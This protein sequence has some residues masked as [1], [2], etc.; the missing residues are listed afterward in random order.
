[1]ALNHMGLLTLAWRGLWRELKNGALTTMLLAL[2]V[3]VAAVTA[4]GFFTDRVDAGMRAQAA[5][6]LAADGRIDAPQPLQTQLEQARALGLRTAQT[7]E[8]PT[9]LVAGDNAQLVT[10]KA[11]GEGYPLRG[12]LSIQTAA[13]AP[14]TTLAQGP[15]PGTL[16]LAERVMALLDLKVGD[17]VQIGQAH[18]TVAAVLLREPD[19]GN[20]FAQA[21]P[22]AMLN[23]QDIAA[24]GLVTPQSRVKHHLL[25]AA[26]PAQR[27]GLFAQ[28]S[29]Q[30]PADLSIERPEN[31]QPA[32]KT[33]FERAARFLGLAAMVAVL[34]A[35]A[36][37][38][39]A[40][41]QYNRVQQD[42]AA[43]MRAF[44]ASRRTIFWLYTLRLGMLALLAAVPGIIFG[45]L[46]QSGLAALLDAVLDFALPPP[47]LAPIGLGVA[48]ALLALLG[49][50]LPALV[51][52]Q[53]TP[54][55]RVLNQQLA[56]PPPAASLLFAAGLLAMGLL[57]W[58]QARDGL[59]TAYVLGGLLLSLAVFMGVVWLLLQG[60]RRL[61][62]RGMAR[63]GLARLARS[64]W[65]SAAQVSALSLGLTALLLLGVVRGDLLDAWRDQAPA[66]APNVFAINIQPHEVAALE[67]AL[68]AQNIH[69]AGV[70]LMHSARLAAVNGV[71]FDPA[72]V[73]G[74]AKSLID[75]QL[76]LSVMPQ[77]LAVD[78]QLLKGEWRFDTP[79]WSV[80]QDMVK[81]L[82]WKLGD[83]L[84]FTVEGQEVSAAITSIRKVNWDSMRPNFFII[85]TPELL[86][87]SAAQYVTSFHLP[88][89][90]IAQQ[91][92]LLQQFPTMTLFD[93]SRI[94]GEV[95]KLIERASQ[96]VQYVFVF[97]L[98]AGWVVL[99]AAFH[100]SE[101]AR[102]RETAILRVL[103]AR[104]AQIWHSLWVEFAVLGVLT[105]LMA[106]LAAGLLGAL[107]AWKLFNL[108]MR[109]D[110]SLWLVG[111]SAGLALTAVLVPWLGRRVLASTPVVALRG[112]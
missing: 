28:M 47:S 68:R 71:A 17:A 101:A 31:S 55:L 18:F 96:A 26:E 75:R 5:E 98:L 15:S 65:A 83:V 63:F 109:F 89:P 21:A 110:A 9:V 49:F 37:L 48:I 84:T 22:R 52:L 64:P 14:P 87:H 72:Q 62:T 59:L 19:V 16:W 73:V 78:N 1:M 104:Q 6:F 50:A 10:L 70:Y 38:L 112:G 88:E 34:L 80:E 40:A 23:L 91:K 103:G 42:P 108:P 25:L 2:V 29:K 94:L 56:A 111:L 97:T 107:L 105:G 99:L 81:Q 100:A 12:E 39:L 77:T 95:R 58:M 93:L 20:F 106:A 30:L 11:V 85:G 44:G 53:D 92:A 4:V 7:L 13:D 32:F 51:R 43:L 82:G 66:D 3:A 86:A 67:A 90:N 102:L 76:N 24:T 61:P 74:R 57:V 79:G 69:G 60:L 36:A 45:A 8:F 41:Q 27:E 54:P 35:G 33:A 46:A